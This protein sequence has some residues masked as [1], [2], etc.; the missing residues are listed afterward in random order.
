MTDPTQKENDGMLVEPWIMRAAEKITRHVKVARSPVF[1]STA[2]FKIEEE[3]KT[4][5]AAVAAE[6]ERCAEAIF[7]DH[8]IPGEFQIRARDAIRQKDG[9]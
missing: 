1:Q 8:Q 4:G 2:E 7:N 3:H 6:T 9:M 5:C